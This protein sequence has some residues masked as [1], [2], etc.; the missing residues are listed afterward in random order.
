VKKSELYAYHR[1][2]RFNTFLNKELLECKTNVEREAV[3]E[4]MDMNIADGME[5]TE[6]VE[7]REKEKKAKK[8]AKGGASRKWV[9]YNDE[10]RNEVIRVL[11]SP[12]APSQ[13][14]LAKS[15]NIPQR[16]LSRWWREAVKS[17][18]VKAKPIRMGR[19][20]KEWNVEK[21][22][23]EKDL[24]ADIEQTGSNKQTI[25]LTEDELL[26]LWCNIETSL[27]SEFVEAAENIMTGKIL[28][29]LYE[30]Y[31]G[32]EAALI[33]AKEKGWCR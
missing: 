7:R 27:K 2:Q 8:R 15:I 5:I 12:N 1:N 9:K 18:E 19:R 22:Q 29:R 32:D 23:F 30:K 16:R 28:R 33:V 17:G 14:E 26:L 4:A 11:S 21:E 31:G 3:R 25:S 6:K 10:I 13:Y 20:K 24:L